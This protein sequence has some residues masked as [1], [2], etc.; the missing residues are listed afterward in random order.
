MLFRMNTVDQ[1]KRSEG[2]N[3]DRNNLIDNN[4]EKFLSC[5]S[6]TLIVKQVSKVSVFLKAIGFFLYLF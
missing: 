2:S 1:N 5:N 6:V 3:L 4:P